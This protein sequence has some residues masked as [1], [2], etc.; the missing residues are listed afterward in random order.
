MSFEMKVMNKKR[1]QELNNALQNLNRLYAECE[2][3]EKAGVPGLEV[4]K[5]SCIDLSDRIARLKEAYFSQ[6]L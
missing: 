5:Q 3:A 2:R 6:E 1:L 4:A